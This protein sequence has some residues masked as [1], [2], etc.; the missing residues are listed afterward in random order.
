MIRDVHP[1]SGFRF[2]YPSRIPDPRVKK[3][4]DPGL[5]FFAAGV[6]KYVITGTNLAGYALF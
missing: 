2:F 4:P 1:G 3:I 6:L 5:L